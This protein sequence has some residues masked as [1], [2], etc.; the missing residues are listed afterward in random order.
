MAVAPL[1]DAEDQPYRAAGLSCLRGVEPSRE[2]AQ[3]A[4]VDGPHL[5]DQ[6]P[7]ADPRRSR[8]GDSAGVMVE[9]VV[10]FGALGTRRAGRD[11]ESGQQAGQG[12]AGRYEHC[13]PRPVA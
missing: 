9:Q 12:E 3:P 13:Y 2:F 7:G 8:S 10:R 5:I 6:H 1:R 11:D 4:G